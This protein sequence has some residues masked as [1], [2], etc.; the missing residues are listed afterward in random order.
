MTVSTGKLHI[1]IPSLSNVVS[2]YTGIIFLLALIFIISVATPIFLTA[3]NLVLVLKQI[4]I[5]GIISCGMTFVI[6]GKGIDLSVGSAVSLIGTVAA[7]LLAEKDASLFAAISVAF[8]I[9]VG[10]GAING[11]M[12]IFGRIPPFIT[13]L[14]TMGALKGITLIVGGGRFIA[15][16]NNKEPI[17]GFIGLGNVYGIPAQIFLYIVIV[18]ISYILLQKTIFGRGIYAI[19]A[20]ENVA[21]LSGIN[22]KKAIFSTYIISGLSAA[23]AS[24]VL[25]SRM[26]S[27]IPTM[28]VG[29]EFQAIV[30][31][32]LGGTSLLGGQGSI[33]AAVIGAMIMGVLNNGLVLLGFS[34]E[35]QKLI[36]GFLF[37]TII[38]AQGYSMA[39]TTR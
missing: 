15:D 39:R 36:L 22:V 9:G 3:T 7:V 10:I 30:A 13:T 18:F 26:G 4:A 16:V 23:I 14:V 17:F 32:V 37:I 29:Y 27:A 31:T 35:A 8:A 1:Q 38:G 28:G 6:I 33:R 19:G 5:I 11:I 21:V 24:L 34:F 12:I 25:V 20:N 2:S